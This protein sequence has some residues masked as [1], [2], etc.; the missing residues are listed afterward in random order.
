MET[1]E[2]QKIKEYIRSRTT[3]KIQRKLI[4]FELINHEI[5]SRKTSSFVLFD[6]TR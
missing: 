4:S 2:K 1:N 5:Y 3:E 6:P